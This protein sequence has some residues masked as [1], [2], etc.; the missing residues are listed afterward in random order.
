MPEY[1]RRFYDEFHKYGEVEI[2]I[3]DKLIASDQFAPLLHRQRQR[4]ALQQ[5]D[6]WI[7]CCN[8]KCQKWRRIDAV[9]AAAVGEAG[10]WECGYK[11]HGV[12]CATPEDRWLCYGSGTLDQREWKTF[13]TKEVSVPEAALK[14]ARPP[15]TLPTA[16]FLRGI[17]KEELVAMAL[18]REQMGREQ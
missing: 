16:E 14:A 12:T 11:G 13:P 10:H 7:Q 9:T 4:I 5:R 8:R 2:T 15:L 1:T 17:S 6:T 3:D 18:E